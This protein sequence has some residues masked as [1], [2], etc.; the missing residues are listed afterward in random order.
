MGSAAGCPRLVQEITLYHT[1]KRV[2]VS[3]R[4]LRDAT[5]HLELYCAFPFQVEP[6]RFR[7]S[8]LAR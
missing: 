6:P 4:L 1:L 5:P 7:Y 8:S 3:L 2:D